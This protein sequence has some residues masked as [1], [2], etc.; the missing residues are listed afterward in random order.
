MR[1][2]ILTAMLL[3][4]LWCGINDAH[5]E[6]V[7]RIAAVVDDQIILYSEILAQ[8]QMLAAQGAFEGRTE[9]SIDSV[10]KDVLGRMI[11]DKLILILAQE[12]T[13]IKV[14]SAQIKD[15]LDEHIR[16]VRSR[17]PSEQSFQSQL[18]DEGLTLKDLQQRYKDEVKN[19]LLKERLLQKEFEATNVNNQEVKDFFAAFRDSL[20]MRPASIKLAHI[21]IRIKPG[22]STLEVKRAQAESLHVRLVAGEDFAELAKQYSD[23]PTGANG[24]DLGF[25]QHGDMVPEFEKVAFSLAPGQI[26]GV[27]QTDF[28]FHIIKA[29]ERDGERLHC[30]HILFSTIPSAEDTAAAMVRADSIYQRV[31]N[32]DDFELAAKES[33]DD[34]DS[35][36]FGGELGWYALDEMSPEF[37]EAIGDSPAGSI[38]SPTMSSEGLHIIKV[39]DRQPERPVSLELDWDNLKELARR[40]KANRKL[41]Q[42]INEARS[43]HMVEVRDSSG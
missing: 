3:V 29:E 19:Q 39:L 24:G 27:V 31:Q 5:S 26:S 21:L 15:A 42:L 1:Y 43:Q 11:E 2:T 38:I 7:D 25:I 16:E 37:K 12:D 28:G 10:K 36:V 13:T 6:V 14:T 18:A 8:V 30:R 35:R 20:P 22:E 9:A 4:V 17:F 32:G 33:S 23:D 40:D 34:T 41:Q